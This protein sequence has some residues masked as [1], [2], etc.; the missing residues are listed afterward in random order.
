MVFK[1]GRIWLMSREMILL[2]QNIMSIEEVL[3][4]YDAVSQLYPYTPPMSIWRAWEYV[5]YQRYTLSEPVLDVGCGD[6]RFFRLVWPQ[7]GNV[8]GVDIE[9]GV[10]EAARQSGVYREVYVT[11]AHQI[12]PP[13]GRFASVFA[14]CSLE[15]MD[16]LPEVLSSIYRSLQPGGYFLCSVVTDKFVEWAALPLLVQYIGEPSRA[17]ALQVDYETYHHLVSSLSPSAWVEHLEEAGFEVVE[18]IPILPEMT[19]RLFLFIDHLWHVPNPAGELGNVLYPHLAALP[20]FPQAFRHV[21]AGVLQMEQNWTVGS[22]AILS[23][24]KKQ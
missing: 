9:A 3:N 17:R 21:L 1:K 12:P 13:A 18:Y 7:L 11:P 24:R 16:R 20:N 8:V 2:K 5:A 6:G 19:S 15:H 23:G 4:G 14:N 10:A 22:G